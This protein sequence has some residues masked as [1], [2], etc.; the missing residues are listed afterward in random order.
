M[1]RNFTPGPSPRAGRD[2]KAPGAYEQCIKILKPII[3]P[4]DW[5]NLEQYFSGYGEMQHAK[6][7]FYPS[8]LVFDDVQS[9]II[10][11]LNQ[12]DDGLLRYGGQINKIHPEGV[13]IGLSGGIKYPEWNEF[14]QF[15]DVDIRRDPP[16]LVSEIKFTHA[17]LEYRLKTL[18]NIKPGAYYIELVLTFYNGQEWVTSKKEVPFKVQNFLERHATGIGWLAIIATV[19]TIVTSFLQIREYLLK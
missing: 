18:K 5:F 4:G 17:P 7:A 10:T 1:I 14:S 2:A 6:I 8:N 15:F 9:Y 16:L 13:M 19:V 12:S 11:G 3:N